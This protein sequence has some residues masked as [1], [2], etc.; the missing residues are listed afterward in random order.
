MSESSP[1]DWV[2]TDAASTDPVSRSRMIFS[3]L[4]VFSHFAFPGALKKISLAASQTKPMPPVMTNEMRHMHESIC[5]N[6]EKRNEFR[7]LSGCAAP[8]R[9]RVPVSIAG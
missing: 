1:L 9:Q 6:N 8:Q 7:T 2:F 3:R 5:H 4:S